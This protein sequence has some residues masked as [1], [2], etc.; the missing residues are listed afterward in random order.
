MRVIV[1][2]RAIQAVDARNVE[3]TIRN[4][5]GDDDCARADAVCEAE[6]SLTEATGRKGVCASKVFGSGAARPHLP[7]N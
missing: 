4:S 1:D 6:T 2:T 5:G 3:L 7:C